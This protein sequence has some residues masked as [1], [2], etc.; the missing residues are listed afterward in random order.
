M[1]VK[2]RSLGIDALDRETGL[3]V[4]AVCGA[5][6]I[7][8]AL[9]TAW[10]RREIAFGHERLTSVLVWLAFLNLASFRSPFV[11]GPYGA[12][13]SMLLITIAIAAADTLRN[14]AVWCLAYAA[15]FVMNLLLPTPLAPPARWMVLLSIANQVVLIGLNVAVIVSA[16]RTRPAMLA[17]P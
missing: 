6:V 13:G 8:A 4:S 5:L 2:L 10:R 12:L 16:W 9:A 1:T 7:I 11:G 14:R 17:P 3:A 15:L